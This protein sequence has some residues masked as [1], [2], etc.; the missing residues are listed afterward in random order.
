MDFD[1]YMA[2]VHLHQSLINGFVILQAASRADT[3]NVRA[4]AT[5]GSRCWSDF[6]HIFVEALAGS[7]DHA[8]VN[9]AWG[10]FLVA[11]YFEILQ[12]GEHS[13]GRYMLLAFQGDDPYFN[14]L[15]RILATRCMTQVSPWS[16]SERDLICL[17]L[18]ALDLSS[19]H[20]VF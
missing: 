9:L 11:S 5:D 17:C 14:K 4:T 18:F 6:G 8:V 2:A 10:S 15:I 7:L 19:V 3:S 13:D 1:I 20:S 16:N 12:K